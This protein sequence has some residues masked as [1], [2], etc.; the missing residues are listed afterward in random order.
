M[1]LDLSDVA[2][3]TPGAFG[4]RGIRAA[5][6]H[7]LTGACVPGDGGWPLPAAGGRRIAPLARRPTKPVFCSRSEDEEKRTLANPLVFAASMPNEWQMRGT[8]RGRRQMG[9]PSA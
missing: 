1:A 4:P 8:N 7:R 9:P 6:V 5:V 2:L 3:V